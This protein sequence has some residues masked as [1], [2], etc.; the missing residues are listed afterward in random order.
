MKKR[1]EAFEMKDLRE[2]WEHMDYRIVKDYG[3]YA[4]GHNLHTWDD[5]KRLLA[6][7]RTCGGFI[8]IQRSEFHSFSDGDDSYYTDYFPV[9]NEEEAE[10]YNELY[11]GFEIERRFPGRYLCMTNLRL[12]W[13]E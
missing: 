5:G 8:L 1:C 7:C 12:H 6:K 2:A 3:D 13:S 11:D 4:N 9:E 10:K